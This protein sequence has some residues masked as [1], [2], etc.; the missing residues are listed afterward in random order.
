MKLGRIPRNAEIPLKKQLA[1][2]RKQYANFEYLF[3]SR[4]GLETII[5]FTYTEEA[6]E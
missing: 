4:V 5:N 1:E 3:C 2:L 6:E